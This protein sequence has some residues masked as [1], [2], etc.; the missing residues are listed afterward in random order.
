MTPGGIAEELR[1][2]S[3]A[4]DGT[5]GQALGSRALFIAQAITSIVG[6]PIFLLAAIFTFSLDLCLED[7]NGA[8]DSMI[9]LGKAELMHIAIIPTALISAFAP[10]FSMWNS[11]AQEVSSCLLF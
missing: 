5:W 11:P 7:S 1:E 8:W 10:H 3:N 9:A 6:L 2:K 4:Q